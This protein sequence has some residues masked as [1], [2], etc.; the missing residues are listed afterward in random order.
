MSFLSLIAQRAQAQPSHV[1][2]KLSDGS[3]FTYRE[4]HKAIREVQ[5][6][7][8]N[9]NIP[10]GVIVLDLQFEFEYIA[11][12]IACLCNGYQVLPFYKNLHIKER[13]QL[14][15]KVQPSAILEKQPSGNNTST[16]N[17]DD[18][19]GQILHFTSGSFGLKKIV[20]RPYNNL[21]DEAS[22]VGATL[23][24]TSDDIVLVASP[25]A[26]SFGCGMLR[27]ILCAGA[28]LAFSPSINI[29]SRV[30]GIR[31][32]LQEN[33]TIVTGVPYVFELLARGKVIRSR[34]HS[35]RFFAGGATLNRALAAKWESLF[36]SP[37]RQEYGL[38]EGG[39][40]SFADPSDPPESIGSP[41]KHVRFVIDNPNSL[42]VG[43]LV[44]YRPHPPTRYLFE[45]SPET[46]QSDGGI[47]SGDLAYQDEAKRFFLAGRIKGVINV[48][49]SKVNPNEIESCL[50][51]HANIEE[52]V[53]M[54]VEDSITGEKPAA[55]V[56]HRDGSLTEK[57]YMRFLSSHL[58]RFK[59]PDQIIFVNDWPRTESGKIDFKRLKTLL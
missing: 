29:H 17:F 47:R 50:M 22:S 9:E 40:S 53:V 56:K 7:L 24:I 55:F 25:L 11:C 32:L 44:V 19:E 48:A 21:L 6:W 49:G 4:I 41:I 42:G 59:L 39:I 52:V 57:E 28:T 36:N 15:A 54:G 1:A 5:S 31:K 8:V 51:Q 37:L 23:G 18:E 16:R 26:H 3:V 38:G 2:L 58:S 43:E 27:T 35:T 46:F 10:K 13:R 20:V 34:Y 12:L 30:I 45:D 33:I 14:I